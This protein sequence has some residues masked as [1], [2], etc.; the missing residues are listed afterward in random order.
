MI[1]FPRQLLSPSGF[2]D[3][4]TRLR[5]R[6]LTDIEAFSPCEM[7]ARV[8]LTLT[9]KCGLQPG[10]CLVLFLG[11]LFAVA[12]RMCSR[13]SVCMHVISYLGDCITARDARRR[14]SM[15]VRDVS[16]FVTA[17]V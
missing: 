6:S 8:L 3:T 11:V 14:V 17:L 15:Y 1:A 5:E 2:W 12:Y 7:S 13:L 9:T 10:L 16:V 4:A